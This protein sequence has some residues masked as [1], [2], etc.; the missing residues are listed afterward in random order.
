MSVLLKSCCYRPNNNNQPDFQVPKGQGCR[1][2][3]IA[4]IWFLASCYYA[5]IWGLASCYYAAIWGLASCYYAS[6]WCLA[7][8]QCSYMVPS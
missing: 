5:A 3:Y 6:I 2:V 1:P 4:A 8:L 7:R